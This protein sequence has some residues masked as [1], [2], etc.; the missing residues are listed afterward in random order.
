MKTRLDSHIDELYQLPIEEFTA[1]RNALARTLDGEDK[2]RVTALV[3]PSLPMWVVNQLYWKQAPAYKALVD[4]S[5]KLRAAHRTALA[6]RNVDTRKPDELHKT[7]LEKAFALAIA[8]AQKQGVQ[9]TDASRDAIRRT[10]AALPTDEPAGRI[11][12]EPQAVGFSLLTGVKPRAIESPKK[13]SVPEP[14]L[15]AAE[16]R[17]QKLA[18]QQA[19]RIRLAAERNARRAEEKARKEE[20]KRKREIEKA[21]EALREAERRLAQLK[22]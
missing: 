12:R 22:R 14:K 15:S 21:E 18:E 4:A 6:G 9:I 3:K 13:Q 2:K 8:A 1:A 17:R 19:E 11:T 16:V 20:E 10:L 7:T 5:E